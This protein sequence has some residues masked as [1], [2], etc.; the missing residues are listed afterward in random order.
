MAG[1]GDRKTNSDEHKNSENGPQLLEAAVMAHKSG[2]IKKAETLYIDT[3][4]SG[5][6][7]EIAFSNL[8]VI[9]TKTNRQ[10]EAISVYKRAISSN[11]R[12]ADAYSNLGSL[13]KEVGDLDQALDATL[14]SLELKPKNPNT[15]IN[16]GS[17]YKDLRKLDQALACT[18][19]SLE[20][21]PKILISTWKHTE[22]SATLIRLWLHAQISEPQ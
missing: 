8:G 16:L 6:L 19:Q 14:K 15:L 10:A 2:D 18:L 13:L 5:F 1:F 17:I 9:Y 4:N 12:F 7:H 11:P 3:L 21:K 22:L 20:L